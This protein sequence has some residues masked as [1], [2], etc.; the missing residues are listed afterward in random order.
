MTQRNVFGRRGRRRS[1]LQANLAVCAAFLFTSSL[2][3]TSLAQ[4]GVIGIGAFGGS[5]VT[6]GFEGTVIGPNESRL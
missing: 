6:E 4:A 5:A 3:F 1:R 2:V